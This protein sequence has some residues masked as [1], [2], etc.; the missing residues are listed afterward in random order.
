MTTTYTYTEHVAAYPELTVAQRQRLGVEPSGR[1]L[2]DDGLVGPRT[3]SGIFVAPVHEHRLVA[4]LLLLTLLNMREEGG[5]NRGRWPAWTMG[6]PALKDH[7]PEQIAEMSA[8]EVARWARVQQGA[9]CAGDMSTA[10]RLAYGPG[11]PASQG[12]QALVRAWAR[13]PGRPVALSE[14]Q[15][16]DLISWERHVEGQPGAGHVGGV[17]GRSPSGLLLTLEGN[18]SRRNG[19]M[20]LYGYSLHEG[21]PRDTQHVT[22]VARRADDCSHHLRRASPRAGAAPRA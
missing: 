5:N 14:A 15:A 8:A 1:P 4:Q 9:H 21:A 16:G 18:G 13:K 2:D 17:C 6:E 7:T 20:G 10:I 3:R 19:A 11:Q 22:L 12:A